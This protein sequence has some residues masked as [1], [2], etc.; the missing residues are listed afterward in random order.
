MTPNHDACA[1]STA[2]TKS[3]ATIITPPAAT[4]IRKDTMRCFQK[5]RCFSTPHASFTADVTAPKTPSDPQIKLDARLPERVE[6]RVDELELRRKVPEDEGKDGEAIL[7]VRRDGA[8]QRDDEQ[9]EREER[10]QRV[11]GDRGCVGEVVAGDELDESTPGRES[12]EAELRAQAAQNPGG[13]HAGIIAAGSAARRLRS[14]A[15]PGLRT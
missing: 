5:L 6:L 15:G 9:E 13:R 12:R 14:A 1:T 7:L 10:Q 8:E 3:S 4:S 11:V 2:D